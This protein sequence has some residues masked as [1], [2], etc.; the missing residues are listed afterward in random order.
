M[1][2]LSKAL[3]AASA[4][5]AAAPYL[6]VSDVFGQ[7]LYD[8]NDQQQ[9]VGSGVAFANS[10]EY[11]AFVTGDGTS[12]PHTSNSHATT[13]SSNN[14]YVAVYQNTG[15]ADPYMMVR[16]Y[17]E[18]YKELIWTKYLDYDVNSSNPRLHYAS[19]GKLYLMSYNSSSKPVLIQMDS[20]TGTVNWSKS[21]TGSN[22]QTMRSVEEDASGTYVYAAGSSYTAAVGTGTTVGAL[23]KLNAS[24][25]NEVWTKSLYDVVNNTQQLEGV[26]VMGSSIYVCG[27]THTGVYQRCTVAQFDTDGN[28]TTSRFITQGNSTSTANILYD[29]VNDGTYIYACGVQQNNSATVIARWES[30]LNNGFER[31][32]LFS[33][34]APNAYSLHLGSD[35]YLYMGMMG[36][37]DF[38]FNN[39]PGYLIARFDKSTLD[40]TNTRADIRRFISTGTAGGSR[41]LVTGSGSKPIVHAMG[42]YPGQYSWASLQLDIN[43]FTSYTANKYLPLYSSTNLT[44]WNTGTSEGALSAN[45]GNVDGSWGAFTVNDVALQPEGVIDIHY[46]PVVDD[47]PG[48]LVWVKNRGFTKDGTNV[49]STSHQLFD[50]VRGPTVRILSNTAGYNVSAV[51][52]LESFNSDGFTVGTNL[53]NGFAEGHRYQSWSFKKHEKFFDVV[54]Y[55]G[56]GT[57]QE[58]AHNLGSVPGCIIVKR[59]DAG[60]ENWIVY[61]H[62][63]DGGTNPQDYGMFLNLPNGLQNFAYWGNNPGPNYGVAP[64]A[65][66]FTVGSDGAT[67]N[68]APATYI[69]YL[70]AHN[71]GDGIFGPNKDQDIIKCGSYTGSGPT[72]A[73]RDFGF[74]PQWMMVKRADTNNGE[75]IMVDTFRGWSQG[76]TDRRLRANT[77][78]AEGNAECGH[79]TPTGMW[80][81]GSGYADWNESGIPYIYIAIRRG[82]LGAP[83]EPTDV[84]EVQTQYSGQPTIE[85][86]FAPDIGTRFYDGGANYPGISS[87]QNSERYL[88]MSSANSSNTLSTWKWD[89]MNGW[90]NNIGGNANNLYSHNWKRAP[91]FCETV[92]YFGDASNN[93]VIQHGLGAVPEMI[94]V[95]NRD[96]TAPWKVYLHHYGGGYDIGFEGQGINNSGAAFTADA[97]S[98]TFTIDNQS[99]VNALSN[100]FMAYLFASVPGISKIGEFTT[101][102]SDININCGFSN[103]ARY[104]LLK[105]T[106]AGITNGYWHVFDSRQGI[107]SGNTPYFVFYPVQNQVTNENIISPHPSG[108]T[109]HGFTSGIWQTGATV[110]FYAIA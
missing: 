49:G 89:Y 53:S 12:A 41:G 97:T 6:D 11:A 93:R 106:N 78:A 88:V 72:P 76:I 16:K 8:G 23:S 85:T 39:P 7:A 110:T 2:K 34:E 18:N 33:G 91:K 70:F 5:G 30:G 43:D 69:A 73:A 42:A 100:K 108:F 75:W 31:F 95:K 1:A 86:S 94:W 79:P 55:V 29:I 24:N 60:S 71:D 105:K 13:D 27:Q 59:V 10:P 51:S 102:G 96:A 52:W 22:T 48:G 47:S 9:T 104:V 3:Q 28:L 57:T 82:P 4:S 19:S 45:S 74:E 62:Q 20:S 103:G 63:A 35:G 99:A 77:S 58:I 81:E 90:G 109:M 83:T 56:N 64:T 46:S 107:V 50:T 61:H 87:R 15:L 26:T 101:T 25:G 67:N 38:Y 40:I 17:T 66:H 98:T 84:F 32:G 80:T 68:A 21:F 44:Q 36:D 92:N 54:Q 65:T 37:A 14:I